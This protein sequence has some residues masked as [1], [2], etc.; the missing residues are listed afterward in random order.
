MLHEADVDP[1]AMFDR[2]CPPDKTGKR[3]F[4]PTMLRRLK[5]LGIDKTDPRR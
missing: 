5:K 2:L 4:A 1:Q 3:T